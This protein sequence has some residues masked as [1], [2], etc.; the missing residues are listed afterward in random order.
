V[1]QT[2]LDDPAILFTMFRIPTV[3][4]GA[5]TSVVTAQLAGLFIESPFAPVTHRAAAIIGA[6]L[7]ASIIE[8]GLWR[9]AIFSALTS[10]AMPSGIGLGLYLGLGL[11]LGD[12]VTDF[13]FNDWTTGVP[14]SRPLLILIGIA[15]CWWFTRC[16]A[17]WVSNW[18][19]RS[20]QIPFWIHT[21]AGF[22]LVYASLSWWEDSHTAVSRWLFD[23]EALQLTA[24]LTGRF[25]AP[26]YWLILPVSLSSLTGAG[27]LI[28][29]S[30]AWI[31]PLLVWAIPATRDVA[32]WAPRFLC[33]HAPGCRRSVTYWRRRQ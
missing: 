25:T 10:Q 9:V 23:P 11:I 15:Y 13:D 4:V 30:A 17:L 28:A 12:I 33:Y 2:A 7:L 8:F 19:G 21:I 3:A 32:A 18:T 22:V 29:V 1:R 24:R 27:V 6:A 5:A 26:S 14:E 20:L 31:A 16:A